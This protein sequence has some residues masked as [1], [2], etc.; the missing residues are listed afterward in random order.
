MYNTKALSLKIAP[1]P[2]KNKKKKTLDA[3]SGDIYFA[4]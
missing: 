2:K 3:R 4:V 1:P